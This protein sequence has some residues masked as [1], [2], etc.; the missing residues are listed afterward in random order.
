M[1]SGN[2]EALHLQKDV[3]TE[4]GCRPFDHTT[5]Y[6]KSFFISYLQ[7][8]QFLLLLIFPKSFPQFQIEQT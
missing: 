2:Y 4:K 3:P 8:L 5:A 7:L 1:V 6:L